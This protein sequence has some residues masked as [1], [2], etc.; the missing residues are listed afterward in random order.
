MKTEDRLF[1]DL[2]MDQ[3]GWTEE[4]AII[5]L[6]YIVKQASLE[7]FDESVLVGYAWCKSE[8]HDRDET[9]A[10][11][12]RDLGLTSASV[13]DDVMKMNYLARVYGYE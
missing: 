7:W 1:I 13:W 12:M 5:S 10:N 3:Y 6:G 2:A 8:N 11:M 9:R 4:D